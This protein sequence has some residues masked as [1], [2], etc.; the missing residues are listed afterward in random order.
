MSCKC[1]VLR[2]P[3][4]IVTRRFHHCGILGLFWCPEVVLHLVFPLPGLAR[5]HKDKDL[6]GG[7]AGHMTY[8]LVEHLLLHRG[9]M[10]SAALSDL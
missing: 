8:F 4:V 5:G 3:E 2:Y 7:V 6:Y 1:G 10:A 9:R